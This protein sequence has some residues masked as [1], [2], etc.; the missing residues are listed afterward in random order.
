MVNM[1][2]FITVM[3][4]DNKHTITRPVAFLSKTIKKQWEENKN[5]GTS[6]K[7]NIVVLEGISNDA[8]EKFLEFGE[9]YSGIDE[10]IQKQF[11]KDIVKYMTNGSSSSEQI[12][13]I[14]EMTED[15]SSKDLISL[16]SLVET[17]DVDFMI[18]VLGYKLSE[19]L[20]KSSTDLQEIIRD[21]DD[22]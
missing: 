2:P 6:S 12:G 20:T 17:I 7:S 19:F 11:M 4:E 13:W 9:V 1:A 15:L 5:K 21:G 18:T 8:F 16:M 14:I 22:E 3:I 10:K